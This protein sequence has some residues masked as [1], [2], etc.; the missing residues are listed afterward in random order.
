MLMYNNPTSTTL[1]LVISTVLRTFVQLTISQTVFYRFRFVA[2]IKSG[3][4][5]Y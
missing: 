5:D 4:R 3:H 1:A 2:P